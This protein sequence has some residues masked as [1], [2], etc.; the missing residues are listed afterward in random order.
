MLWHRNT[1]KAAYLDVLYQTRDLPVSVDA[2]KTQSLHSPIQKNL[3]DVGNT[4]T[5][6]I[7]PIHDT[8]NREKSNTAGFVAQI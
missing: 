2:T 1:A 3:H 8:K 6:D 5:T 4:S 7:S